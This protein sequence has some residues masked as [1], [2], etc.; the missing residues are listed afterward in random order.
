MVTDLKTMGILLGN[1]I[2]PRDYSIPME[3]A[4]MN[5][6]IGNKP[7]DYRE[8]FRD[9]AGQR[10]LDFMAT[11]NLLSKY[12]SLFNIQ[13]PL[14]NVINGLNGDTAPDYYTTMG[15]KAKKGN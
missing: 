12:D 1:T 9:V 15:R 6:S 13:D 14:L 7:F 5:A 10:L 4:R 8:G 2:D 3:R 11:Q